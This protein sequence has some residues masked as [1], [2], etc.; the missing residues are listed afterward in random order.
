[1]A[2]LGEMRVK[3]GAD[4]S[5]LLSKVDAAKAKLGQLTEEN[6]LLKSE[7]KDLNQSLKNNDSALAKVNATIA[8]STAITK[9]DRAAVAALRKERDLLVASNGK[10][11]ATIKATQS[12]LATNTTQLKAQAIAVREAET[13][14][15]WVCKRC[16]KNV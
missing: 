5:E 4:I 3:V 9:E 10:I 14:G 16:H 1:M 6:G 12:D 13:A 8:K 11:S 15:K 7:L 2:D